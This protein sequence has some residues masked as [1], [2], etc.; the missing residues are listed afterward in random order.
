MGLT[1]RWL[2]IFHFDNENDIWDFSDLERAI[3]T[4]PLDKIKAVYDFLQNDLIR[5]FSDL[6][7]GT[8]PSGESTSMLDRLEARPVNRYTGCSKLV[9]HISEKHN[10]KIEIDI[11]DPAYQKFYKQLAEL[12]KI[13]REFYYV[14]LL[15][16]EYVYRFDTLA[17]REP[18]FR[19]LLNIPQ[20]RY[21]E[22]LKLLE[23]YELA[24]FI[25]LGEEDYWIVL[26][27]EF[28]KE[29]CLLNMMEYI[30][31]EG[32]DKKTIFVDLDFTW[33]S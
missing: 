27:K 9:A 10:V 31:D 23:A 30:E 11:M 14:I 6:D 12:P 20:T 3:V 2:L 18:L 19:R 16:S 13:T 25:D 4:L 32:F 21:R 33:F 29:P 24:Y 8:T 26:Y 15:R 1:L 28:N 5:V 7:V 17:V 22:E